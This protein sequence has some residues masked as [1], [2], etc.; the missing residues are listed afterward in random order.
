MSELG[1][2]GRERAESKE[3]VRGREGGGISRKHS[4][5]MR[6]KGAVAAK[7]AVQR[8]AEVER[9]GGAEVV[10]AEVEAAVEAREGVDGQT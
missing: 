7:G 8:T 5:R 9:H 2:A 1:R 3:E 10:D 4:R 6:H